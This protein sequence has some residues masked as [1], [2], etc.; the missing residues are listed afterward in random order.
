MLQSLNPQ[1]S[2]TPEIWAGVE[3]TINRVGNHY[4]DQLKLLGHDGRYEKDLELFAQLGIKTWRYP[5]L[6]EKIVGVHARSL[7]TA[8]W[9]WADRRLNKLRQLGIR[10]IIG[11]LH[12]GSGPLYT[13]LMHSTF[14]QDFAS[15]A[16]AF[17][18]RYPWVDYYTPVNEPL[19]TARFAGLYGHWYPHAQNNTMFFKAFS[20]QMQAITQAMAAIRICNPQAQ[21]VQTEDLGK[22]YGTQELEYQVEFENSRRW[23]TY[24]TLT[25]R[26]QPQHPMWEFFSHMGVPYNELDKLR[27]CVCVPQI[28][29]INHYITSDRYL[30]PRLDLYPAH[31]HAGNGRD[32]YVDIAMVHAIP[33]YAPIERSSFMVALRETWARYR[34]PVALTEV[35]LAGT[36]EAQLRWFWEAWCDSKQAKKEGIDSIAVTA[37]AALGSIDWD[38]LVTYKRG[39]YETG[40]YD[41]RSGTP[42]PT[43]IANMLYQLTTNNSYDHP[44]LAAHGWWRK[45]RELNPIKKSQ[46]PLVI[47]GGNGTLG[48]NF[49]RPCLERTISALLLSHN[50]MDITKRDQVEE[51]LEQLNPWAVINAAGYVW[52]DEAE[53]HPDLCYRINTLGPELLAKACCARKIPFVTFSSDLVFDGHT[54]VPYLESD[55]VCPLGIYG[56]SKAEAE[57]RV[58]AAYPLA[59]VIRTSAFFSPLDEHNFVFKVLRSLVRKMSFRA[60]DDMMVSPTYVPDLVH[61]TLDLL[62]DAESGLWHVTN[63]GGT[64]WAALAKRAAE[65]AHL[66]SH[67][68]KECTTDR[69][70]YLAPRP[71]YSA[72]ASERGKL[73]FPWD[74]ALERYIRDSASVWNSA[75]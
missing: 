40:I 8:N 19:T 62:I 32:S 26:F 24:D 27:Q 48:Q 69:L 61:A 1:D 20:Q 34:L 63:A 35:H 47:T 52:V 67:L 17:A 6:W 51:V 54:N 3:C 42:R 15:F 43:A 39:H 14:V 75:L 55:T 5:I 73:L 44:V 58:F 22:V 71:R 59:L 60:A 4:F 7:D 57:R 12:H 46:Q 41:I 21:L 64:T 11:L 33:E 23:L 70:G 28:I 16:A 53:R 38:S 31:P 45:T 25:G 13:G 30:D 37:W 74:K 68:V 49:Q 50:E 9:A 72:L 18:K 36:R 56:L 2:D 66:D 65:I 10:P 29:G